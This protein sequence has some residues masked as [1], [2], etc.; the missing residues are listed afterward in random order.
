MGCVSYAPRTAQQRPAPR[1]ATLAD[2]MVPRT[3]PVKLC[4]SYSALAEQEEIIH[5]WHCRVPRDS[6]QEANRENEVT[7]DEEYGD[8]LGAEGADHDVLANPCDQVVDRQCRLV[9]PRGH[10]VPLDPACG[11]LNF[12]APRS[13]RFNIFP[14]T[15]FSRSHNGD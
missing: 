1:R 11:T 10:Q 15:F 3:M 13:T 14:R 5:P 7:L 9:L 8:Y 12:V 2:F 6:S 4:N